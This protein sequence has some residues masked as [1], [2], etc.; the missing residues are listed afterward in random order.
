MSPHHVASQFIGTRPRSQL[1]VWYRADCIACDRYSD[2]RQ[3]CPQ[4]STRTQFGPV[5]IYCCD[6][7]IHYTFLTV[8]ELV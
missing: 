4:M 5:Q 6:G 8:S 3:L 2:E 7:L 1:F